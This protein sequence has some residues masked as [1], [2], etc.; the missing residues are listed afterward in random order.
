MNTKPVSD[1]IRSMKQGDII[2]CYRDSGDRIWIQCVQPEDGT[3]SGRYIVIDRTCTRYT[4]L[5]DALAH[6]GNASSDG[7]PAEYCDPILVNER[8]DLQ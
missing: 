3:G 7:R 1:R 5:A 6:I 8:R 2:R 4:T